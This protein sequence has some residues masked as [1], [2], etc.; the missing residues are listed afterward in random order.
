MIS[1]GNSRVTSLEGPSSARPTSGMS[2]SLMRTSPHAQMTGKRSSH[3]VVSTSST[4]LVAGGEKYLPHTSIFTLD[5]RLIVELGR[6]L[7]SFPGK[8][9][10]GFD[11][12]LLAG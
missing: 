10:R 3:C 4:A 5:R 2:F 8:A 1:A 12:A 11:G 7:G 6:Y 9:S